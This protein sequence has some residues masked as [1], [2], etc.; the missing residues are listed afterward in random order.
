MNWL[1]GN[2]GDMLKWIEKLPFYHAHWFQFAWFLISRFEQDKCRQSA[3]SLTY[4]TL[5][6]VVPMLTV[7]IVT[8]NSFKAFAPVRMQVQNFIYSNLLPR[9]GIAVDRYLNDFTEK[10]SNLTVIGIIF[11]FITAILMLSSIE[12]A[13]NHIWRVKRSR[14]GMMGFMRYWMIISL[15]PILLG[16]AFAVSSTLASMSLLNETIGG[17]SL[18]I[19]VWVWIITF[20]LTIAGFTLLNWTIPN[21]KVPFHSALTAG[22]LCGVLFELSRTL[23][24]WIM[25]NFT[26]YELIYGAF[27]A[28]PIFLLWIYTSWNVILLSVEFSYCMTVY[29]EADL[30]ARH[31]VMALLD[32]LSL[33][34]KK[35]KTGESVSDTEIMG[36]LGR[37]E[38]E[39][40]ADYADLLLKHQLI[41]RTDNGDYVLSRNL[42]DINFW[43]FY[44]LLSYPLPRPDD[45]QN[46]EAFGP[47]LQF[48]SPPLMAT[49]SLMS[50]KLSI[51]LSQVFEGQ[52]TLQTQ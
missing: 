47:W 27:A 52:T 16:S 42:N 24:G 30:P 46:K 33:F 29:K 14:W 21:C 25:G 6:A 9:S 8:L 13:F 3:G 15:G 34:Y 12:D 32:I 7:F 38:V 17:Y 23:F 51:P 39:N 22:A 1:N 37:N 10:S 49:D 40:W 11:I 19:S 35:Q 4:T 36:I 28:F 31:P 43:S 20:L 18:D 5:F 50:E 44:K 26:S 48:I 2:G 45:W 41:K